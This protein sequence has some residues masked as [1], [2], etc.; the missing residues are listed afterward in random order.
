MRE[1]V[2]PAIRQEL[3]GSACCLA[4][5][6]EVSHLA[7]PCTPPETVPESACR[8]SGR[9]HG[10]KARCRCQACA[11]GYT[12]SKQPPRTVTEALLAAVADP[13]RGRARVGRRGRGGRARAGGQPAARPA[14]AC[15]PGGGVARGPAT[16]P[17]GVACG[18]ARGAPVCRCTLS[19]LAPSRTRS[20]AMLRAGAAASWSKHLCTHLNWLRPL[21]N[22]HERRQASDVLAELVAK[23]EAA[24]AA[25]AAAAAG[26]ATAAGRA[27]AVAAAA[28]PA[29]A[30]LFSVGQLVRCTVIG[31][32]G[33]SEG[34]PGHWRAS[35]C[36]DRAAA[37]AICVLGAAAAQG[38]M[39]VVVLP[40][41]ERLVPSRRWQLSLVRL[42]RCMA[43]PVSMCGW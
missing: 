28:V 10:V 22:P 24:A 12:L 26:P 15:R 32:Q 30:E 41:D 11:P 13:G 3:F 33:G 35:G 4:T 21:P 31:K 25:A 5:S 39:D 37:T 29:L 20:R 19:A 23:A 1:D 36:C 7:L 18:A 34:A 16:P 42:L 38:T 9:W 17:L 2:G 6:F 27:A 8:W 40:K 43:H 14:R